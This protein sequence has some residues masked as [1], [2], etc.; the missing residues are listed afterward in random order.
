MC[1]ESKFCRVFLINFSSDGWE[2]WDVDRRPLIRDQMPILVDCD[3][4]FEDDNAVPRPSVV[5]NRWLRELPVSGAPSPRTWKAYAQALRSWLEFLSDRGVEPFESRERLRA[6]LGAYAGHRLSGSLEARWDH[7][8]WNLHMTALSAFYE[9]ALAE[10]YTETLPFT[11]S[12]VRRYSDG[13]VLEFERNNAKL[14]PAKPHSRVKYLDSGSMKLFL[15]ALAGLGPDGS[16]DDGFRG[17]ELGRNRAMGGLV[18]SSGLRSQE[19]SY[20]LVYELP[21]LPPQPTSVPVPF[22]L[23]R[24]TTKGNKPRTT[25]I[26]YDALA[27]VHQYVALERAVAAAEGGWHPDRRWGAPLTVE[28]PDWEGAR[29]D[30]RRRSWQGLSPVER[31]R[32][33]SPEGGSC[34]LALQSNGNPFLDWATMFRRTSQRIR[35]R[36]APQFPVVSP[37][38]LRHSFA[39]ATLERL[40]KGYYQ[41]A[42]ALVDDTDADAGLALYLTKADPLMVLRDLLG[43]SSVTTTEIYLRRLDVR[44]IYKD[45]YDRVGGGRYPVAGSVIAAEVD[46]E[47]DSEG[48]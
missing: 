8:T 34:L 38:R 37:H 20:L 27:G 16:P 22:P 2:S 10:G 23:G 35:S 17:R 26:D 29:I 42:A 24:G 48:H 41:Q 45:A 4:R 39:M 15:D 30:G 25:W 13:G 28:E 33:V 6:V 9:W 3:L 7:S 5:A 36:F 1:I 32:L 31:L 14:R 18:M 12:L 46:D 21:A 19:F 47:F 44:R 11:Y 43:H 40:V